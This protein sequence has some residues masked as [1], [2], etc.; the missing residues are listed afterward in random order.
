MFAGTLGGRMV[1]YV[2]LQNVMKCWNPVLNLP[3]SRAN[4][5]VQFCVIR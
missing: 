4:R 5:F 1:S 3:V 2:L